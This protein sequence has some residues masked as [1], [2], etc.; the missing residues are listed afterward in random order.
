MT[1]PASFPDTLPVLG[2]TKR[3]RV[4]DSLLKKLGR[5]LGWNRSAA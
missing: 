3:Q 4:N 2:H 1:R 5:L